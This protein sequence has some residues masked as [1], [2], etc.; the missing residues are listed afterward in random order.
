MCVCF[1]VYMYLIPIH[2]FF[3][4]F[5]FVG[6]WEGGIHDLSHKS[7][8]VTLPARSK[9]SQGKSFFIQLAQICLHDC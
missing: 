4:S 7:R 8:D 3:L 1:L 5:F 9:S 2:C 6:Y